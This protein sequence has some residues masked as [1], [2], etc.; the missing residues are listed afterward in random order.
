MVLAH[1]ILDSERTTDVQIFQDVTF[2]T[3]LLSNDTLDG[4]KESGFLKPSP[5]QLHAV[6]LG[7]CGFDLILEAKSGTGKTAVFT[8][9]ALENLDLDKDLQ[10]IV[11]APTREIAA[12]I[13]DVFKQIGCKYDGLCVE[14]VMGGMPIQDDIRKFKENKVHVLVASPGR[15]KHLIY[16]KHINTSSVRLLILDEADKLM[17]KSFLPDIKFIHSVL[18]T[19][20]QVILSSATYPRNSK[21]LI[22]QFVHGAQHICPS[23]DCILLGVEQKV[24]FVK[25]HDNIVKQIENRLTELLKILTKKE[26]KQCLIF[27]NYQSR[28]EELHKMLSREK[29]PAEQLYGKQEQNDRL[30]AIKT[31]QEYKCRLLITTDLAARGIDASNVD[32]VINFE[33]P[34]EWQTYLHRIGRAGRYGSYGMAVTILCEGREKKSFLKILKSLKI[35]INLTLLWSE[36]IANENIDEE[37]TDLTT[38]STTSEI[39]ED[40]NY[41]ELWQNLCQNEDTQD[42]NE[43]L[44]SFDDLFK[45][46]QELESN[47]N[48]VM[49]FSDL[50]TSF[51]NNHTSNLDKSLV[52]Q[53]KCLN[54]PNKVPKHYFKRLNDLKEIIL[55]RTSKED[56]ANFEDQNKSNLLENLTCEKSALLQTENDYFQHKSISGIDKQ[57]LSYNG[58]SNIKKNEEI[59]KK[60]DTEVNNSAEILKLGL[61]LAFASSKNSPRSNKSNCVI[62]TVSKNSNKKIYKESDECKEYRKKENRSDSELINTK[63]THESHHS[64]RT[65]ISNPVINKCKDT[66]SG[67]KV[68]QK[69]NTT[70]YYINWY[71]QL[72]LKAKQIEFAI[73]VDELSK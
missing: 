57:H 50:L 45:S 19:Q 9:I 18:P 67:S 53:Y 26:F 16:D 54:I 27:C 20:K 71:H 6:P 47:E 49:S 62:T 44:E 48:D 64:G 10:V 66:S 40:K 56:N 34:F 17:E 55:N 30:D 65:K 41:I 5:I 63:S 23:S 33:P 60:L 21:E 43:N 42:I 1:N 58:K 24:T 35:P 28:V 36:D 15:L 25:Y 29:W 61:P 39:S 11:L 68:Y 59:N 72:K 31:L 52:C 70:D 38:S 8:I 69:N 13:C 2:D 12:Q 73:Y 51:N 7:K 14:V 22:N 4:L 37:L 46:F 3:M 32:L